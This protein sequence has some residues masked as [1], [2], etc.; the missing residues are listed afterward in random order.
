[1]RRDP[2]MSNWTSCMLL[3]YTYALPRSRDAADSLGAASLGFGYFFWREL[4]ICVCTTEEMLQD[5]MVGG[6]VAVLAPGSTWRRCCGSNV[7]WNFESYCLLR[8]GISFS[9]SA[10]LRVYSHYYRTTLGIS[11]RFLSFF[12]VLVLEFIADGKMEN[13]T[14]RHSIPV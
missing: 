5:V 3:I 7:L 4:R 14:F 11:P 8:G 1:M 10:A 6:L 2:V 13:V 12:K 9:Q